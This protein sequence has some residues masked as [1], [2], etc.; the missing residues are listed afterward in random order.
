[1]NSFKILLSKF[2]GLDGLAS[3]AGI[4]VTNVSVDIGA[5][6]IFLDYFLRIIQNSIK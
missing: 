4:R 2:A 3:G 6:A 1:L 5:N